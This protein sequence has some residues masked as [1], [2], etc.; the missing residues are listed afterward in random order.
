M[1]QSRSQAL[2]SAPL[3]AGTLVYFRQDPELLGL[4]MGPELLCRLSSLELRWR[5]SAAVS[6][7]DV[8]ARH[9]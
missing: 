8:K 6:Q 2:A 4:N 3:L 1:R 9:A 5:F 7:S